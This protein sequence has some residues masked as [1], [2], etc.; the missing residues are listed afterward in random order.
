M[1]ERFGEW[2]HVPYI[3]IFMLLLTL[4]GGLGSWALRLE[5]TKAD[6]V[7]V[8]KQLDKIDLKLT[9]IYNL[10]QQRN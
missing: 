5:V 2:L 10:L 8:E 7:D 4:M 1:T 9:T 6:K 3:L